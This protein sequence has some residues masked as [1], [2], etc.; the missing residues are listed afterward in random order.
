L[1]A[2]AKSPVVIEASEVERL[3]SVPEAISSIREVFVH[4][5]RR[6][7]PHRLQ[8]PFGDGDLLTMP[9]TSVDATGT[10]I[11]GVKVVSIRN[12]NGELGLPT[13]QSVYLLLGGQGLSPLAM[14]DGP[15]LT[16]LRTAAVSALATQDL[17]RPGAASLVLF[18]AGA[19]AQAHLKALAAVRE[20]SGVA[21]VSRGQRN[22]EQL[23]ALARDL[24]VPARIG[25]PEDVAEAGIVCCCTTSPVPLF[26]GDLLAPGTHVIAVGSYRPDRR[27]LDEATIR[28]GR[29]V[30]EDRD[31]A[32]AEAGE[33]ALLIGEGRYRRAEIAADLAEVCTGQWAPR[34]DD[35]ITVF[36]SVGI[37][38]ED[39][40]IANLVY[41]RSA[42]PVAG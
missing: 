39:L 21:V 31:T 41:Q 16:N 22:I 3:I 4:G 42:A 36:K 20:L 14:I 32:I 33:L 2:K 18:G 35:D 11:A 15:A 30:V 1:T 8:V 17:A 23:L 6:A 38:V 13:V 19:Q 40:A 28:R 24:G 5:Q 37:A 10:P 26:D 34:R 7:N 27:V 25:R 29:V 12:A 9:A